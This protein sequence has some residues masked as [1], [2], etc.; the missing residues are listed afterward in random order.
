V[1]D[2]KGRER[3]AEPR[4]RSPQLPQLRHAGINPAQS[5]VDRRR[6]GQH[7]ARGFQ[8]HAAL[9]HGGDGA[10]LADVLANIRE[11]HRP[12]YRRECQA[13][14]P[15]D[16]CALLL[17]LSQLGI[18]HQEAVATVVMANRM[19]DD[20]IPHVRRVRVGRLAL[21][22]VLQRFAHRR[23]TPHA[24]NDTP[25]VVGERRLLGVEETERNLGLDGAEEAV[26]QRPLIAAVLHPAGLYQPLRLRRLARGVVVQA[27]AFSQ[28]VGV[29]T[30][31]PLEGDAGCGER[32]LLQ[33]RYLQVAMRLTA[34]VL[35]GV[36]QGAPQR[37][38]CHEG[39][40]LLHARR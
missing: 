11:L 31:H 12:V 21:P 35:V 9:K 34:A 15:V 4:V 38:G 19:P 17:R 30:P 5:L 32:R 16:L 7:L 29:L 24:H 20:H 23:S 8:R 40:A 37:E 13:L 1:L 28:L 25:R 39:G 18:G 3:S 2:P 27:P 10:V 33:R 36:G 6:I 22:L 26:E 14:A